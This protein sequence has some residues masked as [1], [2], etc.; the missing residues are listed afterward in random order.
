MS[1]PSG[2]CNANVGVE[3]HCEVHAR[4]L[5][6]LLQLGHLA[7]LLESINFILLVPVDCESSGV[8]STVF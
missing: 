5:N 3:L 6:E 4:S 7:N 8:V 2:V 1:G